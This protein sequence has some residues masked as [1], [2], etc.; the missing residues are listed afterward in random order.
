LLKK[1]Q[2]VKRGTMVL[3]TVYGD[4]HDIGKNLVGSILKNQ[5]FEIVDL[6]KQ[7]PLETILE[8]VARLRPDAIGLS[9]LLVMTSREM[10]RCVEECHRLGYS[11][12]IIIG[13]AAVN[14][15]FAK[16]IERIDGKHVYSG[17][18]YYAKDAFE[19]TRI[20]DDLK[21]NKGISSMPSQPETT[22]A[23][24]ENIRQNTGVPPQL[25][26]GE[27][28]VPHF[29]GTS[30]IL[31]WETK[32][33][34]DAIDTTRLFKGYWAGG[35]LSPEDF[36]KS[37]EQEFIPTFNRLKKEI[38]NDQLVDCRGMY[39][40]FSVYSKDD[41]LFLLDPGDHHTEIASFHFP[42]VESKQNRS[43]ADFFRPE[44]DIIGIQIVTIGNGVGERSRRFIGEQN[45]Y[46]LGFYLNG[47]GNYLT[48]QLAERITGEIRRGLFIGR[49]QGKRY[50]FGYTGLPG[51]E[52]QAKLFEIMAVE[53]RMGITL[54][55]GF[56]MAPE[57]STMAIF[58]HHPK[59]YYL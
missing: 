35:N 56:Q 58:I 53:E 5:G 2:A 44:G 19:A 6:G 17:G 55:P 57:H 34:L 18:V 37:L 59:A 26:Y 16:R 3:A 28:L 20:M 27:L 14:Q 9:A 13:G 22:T 29:Y 38:L 11:V 49:D 24:Q 52:E 41:S 47:I 33:L 25:T 21:K 54:T 43:L 7:V 12:P 50:S 8:T 10:R 51:V 1:E 15:A 48:E 46:S 31:R 39:G 30:E 40:F 36:A 4:V 42:R 45:S 32:T 23:S